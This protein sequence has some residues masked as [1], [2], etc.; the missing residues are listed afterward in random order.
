MSQFYM[1]DNLSESLDA[2]FSTFADEC[3]G[4]DRET[5]KWLATG[6]EPEAIDRAVR[7]IER[8]TAQLR[9]RGTLKP[10]IEGEPIGKY[11]KARRPRPSLAAVAA[12]HAQRR[13]WRRKEMLELRSRNDETMRSLIR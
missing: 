13:E 7:E 8:E 11:V 2:R 1:P 6:T 5:D 12:Y 10:F 3:T 9:N 4:V